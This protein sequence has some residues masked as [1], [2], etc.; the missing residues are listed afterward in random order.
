MSRIRW[1]P[2]PITHPT[3][4]GDICITHS[5]RADAGTDT[6][7][8]PLPLLEAV[9]IDDCVRDT[10]LNSGS[11]GVPATIDDAVVVV[12]AGAAMGIEAVLLRAFAAAV[13]DFGA[14]FKG[15][16]SVSATTVDG[17]WDGL[18]N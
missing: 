14:V 3:T 18:F 5:A 16:T 2:L 4:A 9:G 10:T 13:T 12:V 11:C 8:D 1:P 17:L 6:T 7:A 15:Y